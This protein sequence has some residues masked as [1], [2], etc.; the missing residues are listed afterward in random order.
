MN[1]MTSFL[2]FFWFDFRRRKRQVDG[3]HA[4]VVKN[5]RMGYTLNYYIEKIPRAIL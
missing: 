4:N 2:N 5:L 1:I 3:L